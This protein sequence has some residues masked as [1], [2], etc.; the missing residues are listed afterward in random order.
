MSLDRAEVEHIGI[1]ARIG[2][3][4]EEVEVSGNS[5]RISWSSLK[6]SANWTPPE[7]PPPATGPKGKR[8]CETT[9]QQALWTLRRP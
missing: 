1:L 6:S 2:L 5:F 4:K 8:L 3:T 7:F 9:Q